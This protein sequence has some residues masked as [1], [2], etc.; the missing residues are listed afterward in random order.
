MSSQRGSLLVGVLIGL[1]IAASIWIARQYVAPREASKMTEAAASSAPSATADTA[2]Q[3]PDAAAS[4][5]LTNEEQKSIG[6]QTVEVRR[7]SIRKEVTASGQV[8]EPET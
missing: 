7:Q 3:S 1:L 6:V 4:I 5:Q 2:T 8:S